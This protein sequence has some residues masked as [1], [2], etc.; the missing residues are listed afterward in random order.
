MVTA[1]CTRR[2]FRFS[3]LTLCVLVFVASLP[4]VWLAHWRN[5]LQRHRET[6]AALEQAGFTVFNCG[7]SYDIAV[8]P[9]WAGELLGENDVPRPVTV[10]IGSGR[11]ITDAHLAL[12]AE[13]P[14]LRSL[15]CGETAITDAGLIHLQRLPKLVQVELMD[16]GLSDAALRNLAGCVH[17]ESLTVW[18]ARLTEDAI[19]RFAKSHP[20]L[21][22]VAGH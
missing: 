20:E 5:V 9:R 2:W 4:F 16:N 3:L 22:F 1:V 17:L 10:L 12:I 19:D 8:I 15:E 11:K 18:D 14:N 13:M 21:F 6:V 7:L